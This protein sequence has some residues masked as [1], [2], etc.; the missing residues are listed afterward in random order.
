LGYI[1]LQILRDGH[2][3]C[4]INI[5]YGILAD[6]HIVIL[7]DLIYRHSKTSSLEKVERR[8]SRNSSG[9]DQVKRKESMNRPRSGSGNPLTDEV[10]IYILFILKLLHNIA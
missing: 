2:I 1:N 6:M 5:T 9:H 8:R 3:T 7:Y 4:Q 10:Y